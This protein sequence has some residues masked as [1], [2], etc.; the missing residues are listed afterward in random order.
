[1][2]TRSWKSAVTVPLEPKPRSSAP[3]AGASRS[4]SVSTASRHPPQRFLVGEVMLTPNHFLNNLEV[5]L[6][7]FM[8]SIF[9]D[10]GPR[11]YWHVPS[12]RTKRRGVAGPV[13]FLLGG[14][15]H[16]PISRARE[17]R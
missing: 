11:S 16:V 3:A 6:V 5:H 8:K 4:S 14:E 12:A 7:V 2:E 17:G 1:M 13:R 9:G 10:V 15:T